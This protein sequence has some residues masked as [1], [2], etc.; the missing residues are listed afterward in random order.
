M[1]PFVKKIIMDDN[2]ELLFCTDLHGNFS[3]FIE[4]L[5]D[6]KIDLDTQIVCC[7]DIID[8]G[9]ESIPLLISFLE[10]PNYFMVR[11]N[12]EDALIMANESP[13]YLNY[14]LKIGGRETYNSI[15]KTGLK[16]MAKEIEDKIP[17]VM[18]IHHRGKKFGIV[19]A[20]IPL[21]DNGEVILEWDEF[22]NLV[23]T[24]EDFRTDLMWG[25]L[26]TLKDLN[27]MDQL[28]NK[29]KIKKSELANKNE[30]IKMNPIINGV[31][32]VISGHYSVENALYINN[33]IWFDTFYL[34]N[35]FTFLS[36]NSSNEKLV[37]I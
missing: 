14:W 5:S 11:G 23:E 30:I 18:E 6:K 20:N 3:D 24:D 25:N 9:T 21:K 34:K 17:F 4:M 22:I 16:Y 36:M 10:N 31:D 13:A 28:N 1:S 2:R 26:N 29:K 15:G 32:F 33:R 37:S 27:F 19:H 12:H 35:K 8:R 7:G